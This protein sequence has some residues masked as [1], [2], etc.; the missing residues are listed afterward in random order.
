MSYSAG[1]MAHSALT[2]FIDP[3]EGVPF[4]ENV[5]VKRLM[6]GVFENKPTLPKQNS[7]WDVNTVLKEME[8][9]TLT[10][11]LLQC[12]LRALNNDGMDCVHFSCALHSGLQ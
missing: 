2:H 11:L 8:S 5:L 1:A 12:L 6:K 3:F 10:D 4:G 7:T 9:W